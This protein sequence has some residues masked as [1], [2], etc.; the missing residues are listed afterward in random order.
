MWAVAQ[1][2]I[3][4]FKNQNFKVRVSNCGKGNFFYPLHLTACFLQG[5]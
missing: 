4:E 5:V 3:L 1:S 2:R